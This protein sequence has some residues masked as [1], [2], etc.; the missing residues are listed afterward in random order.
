[1]LTY[2]INSIP[3]DQV[4]EELA[5]QFNTQISTNCGECTI[6]IP[7]ELGQGYIKGVVFDK[8]IGFINYCCEFREEVQINFLRNKIHPLKFLYV[9]EGEL[10]HYFEETENV[11]VLEQFQYCLLSGKSTIAHSI[12]FHKNS[13]LAFNSLEIN[14]KS[15]FESMSCSI[16][17]MKPSVRELLMD[18]ESKN[19]FYHKGYY[20]LEM[21]DLF[22]QLQ[23]VTVDKGFRKIFLEAVVHKMLL[24]QLEDFTSEVNGDTEKEILKKHEVRSLEEA[25][26]IIHNEIGE[27][28][29]IKEIA[30]RVGLNSNKLQFGFRRMHGK[31]IN[32]YVKEKRLEISKKLLLETS[33]TISQVSDKIGIASKSYFS[34]LFRQK[35][36][37]SPYEFRKKYQKDTV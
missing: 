15:F 31:S 12:R 21:A 37:L 16:Q 7:S 4:M 27:L 5:G 32:A 34:K 30:Y 13:P 20:Y 10:S 35:Y 9:L 11:Q 3:I 36:G 14:R 26:D 28:P 25:H 18:L 8:G 24:T 29:N 22:Q 33:Y 19:A 17:K 1:M 2:N 6:N 23:D